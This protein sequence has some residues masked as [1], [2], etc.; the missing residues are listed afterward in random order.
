MKY[1]ENTFSSIK[2]FGYLSLHI[3][4]NGDSVKVFR[5]FSMYLRD[6]VFKYLKNQS[7]LWYFQVTFF[8]W[9]FQVTFHIYLD[10]GRDYDDDYD[11]EY[12]Y[13]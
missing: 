10:I 6:K 5:L 3:G 13:E 12:Y 9:Y 2:K 1:T 4:G 11:G 7:F 8:F